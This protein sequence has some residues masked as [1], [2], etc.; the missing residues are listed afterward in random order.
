MAPRGGG[1]TLL[2]EPLEAEAFRAYGEVI[3]RRSARPSHAINGGTAQ[4]FDDLARVDAS[5]R[6]GHAAISL[7]RAR[8]RSLPFRIECMERHLRGSQAF[9]PLDAQRWIVVVAPRGRAP[10][11]EQL[12]AFVASGMQGINYARG[13]WHHP[14]IALDREAEFLV[15][16][17]VAEDGREDCEM[18]ELGEEALWVR[19]E[20]LDIRATR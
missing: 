8:P 12:R 11:H 14:L 7:V 1:R 19:T 15:V 9:V 20:L 2:A 13:T 3:D 6:G 4:R 18:C 16:D 10:R 17:R 5:M